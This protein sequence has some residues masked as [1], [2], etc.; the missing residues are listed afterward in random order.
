VYLL[1]LAGQD[2]HFAAFEA[3]SAATGVRVVGAGLALAR[4][5]TERVDR[6]AFTRRAS[7]L[8]AWTGPDVASA[9]AAL[10]A[11]QTDR[12]G[13]VAVRAADV[14]STAGVDTRRA[15]RVLGSVLVDRG[16]AVDLDSPDHELRACFAGPPDADGAPVADADRP[17]ADGRQPSDAGC[18]A[19]GWLVSES[20]RE[21]ATRT[22]TGRPFFQ[23]GSM[24]P[25]LARALVN[26]AGARE[27]RTILDPMCGTGGLLLEAGHVGAR[28]VGTDA[29]RRMVRGS[30]RNFATELD[31]GYDV[32]LADASRLPFRNGAV[33]AA[34]F[35]APYGRQSKVA[36][37]SLAT[38]V[39]DAL[40]EIHRVAD[41]AVVV[42]DR[43]WNGA[44]R[45]AGWTVARTFERRVHRS[46][47]RHVHVLQ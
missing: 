41:R 42:G 8:I 45:A 46:L 28:V 39:G 27:G 16:F 13:T 33:D 6:L 47:V 29:Q 7:D 40:A 11:T 35:D 1:E 2:D 22:P 9:R 24:D 26:V 18:C 38:L 5:V 36:G 20:D 37:G 43:P 12:E 44:A 19:L 14:R 30:R 23:P 21:F 34:V 31:G 25:S 15:E 32:C 17:D 3:A 10:A 4:G